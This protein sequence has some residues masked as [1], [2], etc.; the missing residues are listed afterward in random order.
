MA[1][2]IPLALL[3]FIKYLSKP[4]LKFYYDQIKKAAPLENAVDNFWNNTLPH[5]FMQDKFYGI[6]QEQRSLEGAIEA[7]ADCFIRYIR[8]GYPIKVILMETRRRGSEAQQSTWE[9]AVRQLTNY[10]K[11]VRTEQHQ[12][13]ADE[14]LYAAVTIGTYVRFYYLVP[15]ELELRDYKSTR[16]GDYYELKDDE[17]EVH[18]ILTEFVAKTYHWE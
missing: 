13:A 12:H 10:L 5:Y 8:H 7:R 6:E 4:V 14:I 15:K 16:T 11:L 2:D 17:G 1:H 9:Q 18:K 3:T